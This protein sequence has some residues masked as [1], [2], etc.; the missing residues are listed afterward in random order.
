MTPELREEIIRYK[1]SVMTSDKRTPKYSGYY[2]YKAFL[3]EGMTDFDAVSQ[4]L[5]ANGINMDVLKL[6]TGFIAS[7]REE[8]DGLVGKMGEILEA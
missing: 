2:I 4:Y 6:S 1:L 7:N 5:V 3:D 8:A